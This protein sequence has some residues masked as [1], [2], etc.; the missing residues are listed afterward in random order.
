VIDD[1]LQT[2]LNARG[3]G[4][5][6]TLLGRQQAA[7]ANLSNA[8]KKKPLN[9]KE[10]M[11]VRELF[12]KYDKNE[13]GI[14]S[15]DEFEIGVTEMHPVLK[16]HALGMFQATDKDRNGW[17]SWIEFLTMHCPW[18]SQ[19]QLKF[20]TKKYGGPWGTSEEEEEA[21]LKKKREQELADL[22]VSQAER[23]EIEQVFDSWCRKSGSP[24]KGQ[25]GLSFKCLK[26][27]CEGIDPYTLGEWVHQHGMEGQKRITKAEFVNLVASHYNT[28]SIC[29]GKDA[30]KE[31]RAREQEAL[32]RALLE[33]HN[34]A[35]P[36]SPVVA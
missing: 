21:K 19:D 1:K 20:C 36:P 2:K 22:T 30:E 17:M 35:I 26:R 31:A 28:A 13:D 9:L 15:K 18:L 6:T 16:L 5:I 23:H 29:H 34:I 12:E 8:N 11:Y 27:H 24:V 32:G 14:L 25:R 33:D 4:A 3:G 10:Y 7:G